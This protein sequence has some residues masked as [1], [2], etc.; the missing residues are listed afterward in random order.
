M[1]EFLR[2]F[3][4]EWSGQVSRQN[5][6]SYVWATSLFLISQKYYLSSYILRLSQWR[7]LQYWRR[8]YDQKWNRCFFFIPGPLRFVG[9]VCC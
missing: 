2:E 4:R 6:R 5:T 7:E 1:S 9:N 3:L 8:D